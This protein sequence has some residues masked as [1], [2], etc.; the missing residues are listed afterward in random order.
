MENNMDIKE[1]LRILRRECLFIVFSLLGPAIVAMIVSLLLPKSYT[2]SVTILAPEVESGGSLTASPFGAISRIG[3][4]G[5]IISVQAV[6]AILQSG[7]M[8]SD[9]VVKF[10]IKELY[11]FKDNEAAAKYLK[12]KMI[13][14]SLK[15]DEGTITTF[16]TSKSPELSRDIAA[17]YIENLNRINEELKLTAKKP[18]VKVLDKPYI[19]KKKSAPRVKF[20]MAIAGFLGLVFGLIYIYLKEKIH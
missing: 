12:K 18:L 19:P 16:V 15:E 8:T 1:F 13:Q 9:V 17:F 2:S 5:E 6:L 4:K 3:L 14:I 11:K 10:K 7:R 20:N